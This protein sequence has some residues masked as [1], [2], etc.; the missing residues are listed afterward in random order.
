MIGNYS[1]FFNFTKIENGRKVSFKVNSK[2]KIISISNVD[3]YSSTF[4]EN[5]RLVEKHTFFNKGYIV[6][7]NK[8][9]MLSRMHVTIKFCLLEK[10]VSTYTP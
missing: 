3:K 7:F 1:W 10:D 6:I 9:N 8:K 2:G 5:V 4:I